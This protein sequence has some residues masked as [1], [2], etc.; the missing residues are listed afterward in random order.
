MSEIPPDDFIDD[1]TVWPKMI[2][3]SQCLCEE[4]TARRLKPGDCLCGVVP[5]AQLIHDYNEGQA[6][7]RLANTYPSAVFPQRDNRPNN[8]A[9]GLAATL[10]VGVMQCAPGITASKNLPTQQDLF[11]QTRLQMATMT[12]MRKAIQCCD[13][14]DDV[15]LG[16]Y[17][18]SGPQ[19]LLVGGTWTL[20]IWLG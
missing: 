12:A 1:D 2:M 8:C 10:E 5:G 13:F 20:D 11:E 19:G 3:L 9:V 15:V 14:G 18:P 16:Q 6:W 17:D 7:V 4:L